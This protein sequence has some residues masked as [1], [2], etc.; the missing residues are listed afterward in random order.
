MSTAVEAAVVAVIVATV[1]V[2]VAWPFCR[3][4]GERPSKRCR[5]ATA[6]GWS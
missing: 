5:H 1:V 3:Q 6:A 4:S 2:A